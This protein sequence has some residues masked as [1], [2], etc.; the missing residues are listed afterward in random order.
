MNMVRGESFVTWRN[1]W[2]GNIL[3][4][5]KL[6]MWRNFGYTEILEQRFFVME[7]F[8]MWRI[9]NTRQRKLCKTLRGPL[10]S[11]SWTLHVT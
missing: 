6:D 1:F 3:D 10:E 8:G 7:K 2:C 5:E 9:D 11:E 4:V